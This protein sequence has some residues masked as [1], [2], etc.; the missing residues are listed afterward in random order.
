V[1]ISSDPKSVQRLF[2]IS[3]L[4]WQARYKA[5]RQAQTGSGE[6]S[7]SPSLERRPRRDRGRRRQEIQR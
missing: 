3:P 7:S 6:V 4:E 5:S 2:Q 1:P